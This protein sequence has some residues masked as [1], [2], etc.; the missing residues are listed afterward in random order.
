MDFCLIITSISRGTKKK[1]ETKIKIKNTNK[2]RNSYTIKKQ[3][4]GK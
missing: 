4:L 2:K 1:R 3:K